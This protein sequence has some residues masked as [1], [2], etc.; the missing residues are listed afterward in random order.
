MPNNPY[1]D[2]PPLRPVSVRLPVDAYNTL[3]R[4][5]L[6]EDRKITSLVRWA[7]KGYL[8]GLNENAPKSGERRKVDELA[9]SIPAHVR[10]HE[11]DALSQKEAA[12]R[13]GI[14]PRTLRRHASLGHIRPIRIGGRITYTRQSIEAFQREAA[15][16]KIS[17]PVGGRVSK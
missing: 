13:L 4:I 14:S 5:A 12:K 2:R 16:G 3:R 11:S 1:N 8:A 15:Q 17:V 6:A 7:V 9:A 10:R